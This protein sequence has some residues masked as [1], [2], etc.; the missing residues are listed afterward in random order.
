MPRPLRVNFTEGT[1]RPLRAFTERSV[2]QLPAPDPSGD[3]VIHWD[4]GMRGFGVLCSGTSNAKSYVVKGTVRVKG[5]VRG[6]SIRKVIG[7]TDVFTLVKA[8]IK[9]VE[10]LGGF[11]GGI[12]PRRERS[13]NIT[14]KEATGAFLHARNGNLRP[15]SLTGYRDDI[16]RHLSGWLDMALRDINREMVEAR[17][18]A[19]AEEI[20]ETRGLSG[21]AMANRVMR[22]LRAVWNFTA[23]RVA[24]MPSNPV[25]LRGMWHD[26]QPRERCLKGNEFA[27]FYK[28]ALDLTNGIGADYV[29][30]LLFTGLRRT[31][32]A[33]IKWADV[34]FERK[35]ITIPAANTKANRKLELPMTDVVYGMLKERRKLGR[36]EYV[37]FANSKSGH[38]EEPKSF[39]ADIAAA[40]GVQVSPH[41]LRRTFLTVAEECDIPLLA[42]A[43]LVNHAVP[44]VTSSYVQMNVERL[45][46]P[47]QK[48]A[49]RLKVLC[50][51]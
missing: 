36:T 12:D 39:F 5:A 43:A 21:A 51:I 9:A 35:M 38:V 29:R 1:V 28:A 23:D 42:L 27:K 11:A 24:D 16:E 15:K 19:I 32:A 30:M 46:K 34:D 31:E 25:K 17:H 2:A 7:R 13:S 45:R 26:V 40:S 22:S 20:S 3:Q 47:A 4:P 48:V 33:N 41:D 14:L 44:G 10:M 6:K 18:R 49:D 50:G 37:F 8:R